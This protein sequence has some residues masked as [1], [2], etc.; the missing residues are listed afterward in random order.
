LEIISGNIG[1]ASIWVA[2]DETT[3]SMGRCI[4]NLVAG[5]LDIEIF[6]NSHLICTKV[7]H[8][9][10]HSTVARFVNDRFKVLWLA[11]VQEEKVLI[12]YP[13]AAVYML[14]DGTALR[15]FYS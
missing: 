10:N 14:K 4:A 9:T 1:D 15:V 11:G 7:Q 8:H 12:L 2:V 3:D 5:K 6:S 13:D